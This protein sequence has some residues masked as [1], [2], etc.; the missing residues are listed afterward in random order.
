[1]ERSDE[2]I[3][4]D[5]YEKIAQLTIAEKKSSQSKHDECVAFSLEKKVPPILEDIG[6]ESNLTPEEV[7]FGDRPKLHDAG[8]GQGF[9]QLQGVHR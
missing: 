4:F 6:P 7:Q 8:L 3:L 2:N 9:E 5:C 1:M